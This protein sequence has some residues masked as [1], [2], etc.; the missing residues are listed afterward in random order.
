MKE[1]VIERNLQN[2]KAVVTISNAAIFRNA[3]TNDVA[4]KDVNYAN[5]KLKVRLAKEGATGVYTL[6]TTGENRYAISNNQLVV[7]LNDLRCGVNVLSIR[8]KYGTNIDVVYTLIMRVK[9]EAGVEIENIDLNDPI[10]TIETYVPNPPAQEQADWNEGDGSKP[11]Y[12]KNKPSIPEPYSLPAA[13]A[14]ILG[15]VKI[16]D[17]ITAQEDGTI[18]VPNAVRSTSIDTIWKGTQNQYNA[19]VNP[20]DTTFYIIVEPL[21]LTIGTDTI[22]YDPNMTWAQWVAS[23]YNTFSWTISGGKV[24]NGS[25]QELSI[26]GVA[27]ADTDTIDGN[28]SYDWVTP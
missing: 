17:G 1:I 6:K 22:Q 25:S 10:T 28:A 5:G 8:V 12:I 21:S 13:T 7:T 15:G 23:A 19:I 27:V 16:G 20:A 14:Q 11:A 18:S 9:E 2:R 4:S 26:S 3:E 24:L